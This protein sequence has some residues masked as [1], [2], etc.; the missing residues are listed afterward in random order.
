MVEFCLAASDATGSVRADG[1]D[2][3][4]AA[5][6]DLFYGRENHQLTVSCYFVKRSEPQIG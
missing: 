6:D 5:G 4:S 3:R 2:V 1:A